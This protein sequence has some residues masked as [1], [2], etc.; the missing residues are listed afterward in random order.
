MEG[1]QT[2]RSRLGAAVLATATLGLF[3]LTHCVCQNGRADR[4]P[5]SEPAT[6]PPAK[7]PGEADAGPLQGAPEAPGPAAATTPG[8]RNPK[9]PATLDIGDL[10]EA[11]QA[12][13]V[14]VLEQQFDPCGK[15]VN[16]LESL[17]AAD[18][19]E[20]ATKLAPVVVKLVARGLSKRQ[21]VVELLKELQR[22]ANKAAFEL[23]GTP[24]V[25]DPSAKRVIVEFTDFECPYCKMA[26]EPAKALAK[27]HGAVLYVKHLPLEH[28]QFARKAALMSLAAAR[29][30]KFWEVYRAFFD[31][32]EQ[33]SDELLRKLVG[34]AGVD[35][36]RFDRDLTSPEL[37]A[38]LKRD[39]READ[40]Y[41]IDGTPTFFVDGYKVEFDALESALTEP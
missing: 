9:L 38:L 7:G 6:G 30:G 4:P 27:K 33:L 26:A 5:T 24:Y 8:A 1:T 36:A 2:L 23:D 34:E 37:E 25:G 35:M 10:D 18:T 41:K 13:L 22:T 32:Q 31:H 16:F 3:T 39:E 21:I 29:Q 11:E 17:R 14:S 20:R 40:R 19:C 28:H 12:L 15:P